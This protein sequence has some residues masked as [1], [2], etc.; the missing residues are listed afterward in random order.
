VIS[1]L[2]G[3]FRFQ[4]AAAAVLAATRVAGVPAA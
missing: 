1:L 2:A 3:P 4:V